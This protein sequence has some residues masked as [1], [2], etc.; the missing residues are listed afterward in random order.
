MRKAPSTIPRER[1]P[2]ADNPLIVSV[3]GVRGIVGESL[4]PTAVCELALAY[5]ALLEEQGSAGPVAVARD[6]RPSGRMLEAAVIAGLLAAGRTVRSLGIVAAPTAALAV[7]DLPCAGG[8]MIT[9][10]HNPA[11]WNGL[12]FMEPTGQCLP[13]ALMDRLAHFW[14]SRS[15]RL[16]RHEAEFAV[17]P[18]ERATERHVE[19]VLELVHVPAIRQRRFSVLLDSVHGAGGVGGR[20]LLERL[21]CRI[22]LDHGEPTGRFPRPPEPIAEHLDD[23]GKRVAESGVAIGFTQDPDAD[24]LAIFDE[25]G[26]YLGEEYSLALAAMAIL[27]VR[28]GDVAANLSTSRMLDDIAA[29]FGVRV[30][31]TPVGEAHVAKAMAEHACVLGG[32]GNGGV[33]HPDIVPVRDSLTG[34]ALALD[35]L[36]RE[37]RP[38]DRLVADLPRYAM[39]KRKFPLPPDGVAPMLARIEESAKDARADRRDGLRLDWSDGWIHVRASNT[40]PAFRI[41]AEGRDDA[42]AKRLLQRALSSLALGERLIAGNTLPILGDGSEHRADA[43]M[44]EPA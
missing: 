6:S 23:V 41:V 31:R 10:S 4:T 17:L 1:A 14:R 16:A 25:S 29:R 35:L 18:D 20:L 43:A 26:R 2:A 11:P 3:S 42:A 28:P 12:K 32:E 15:F 24:R 7:A 38:L 8:A 34:M 22:V 30:W 13:A 39:I 37:E 36:A 5:A 19:K 44:G 33:I 27:P 40:E 21:G 9:A